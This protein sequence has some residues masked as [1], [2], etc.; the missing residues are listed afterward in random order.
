M[1]IAWIIDSQVEELALSKSK[2]VYHHILILRALE[3][4]KNY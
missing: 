3:N 2:Y 1:V 4:D